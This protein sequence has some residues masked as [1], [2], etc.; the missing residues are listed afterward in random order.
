MK[1]D[2]LF[3]FQWAS[4]AKKAFLRRVGALCFALLLSFGGSLGLSS[5]ASATTRVININSVGDYFPIS[6]NPPRFN[7]PPAF[8]VKELGLELRGAC[9]YNISG[10]DTF[11]LNLDT[12]PLAYGNVIK[13]N[14][15]LLAN[16]GTLDEIY[17]HINYGSPIEYQLRRCSYNIIIEGGS[18]NITIKAPPHD[19]IMTLESS[20]V[21]G[22][23]PN[24]TINN[25]TLEGNG[26][27]DANVVGGI[28]HNKNYNLVLNNVTV[29]SGRSAW[30]CIFNTGSLI[31]NRSKIM[32]CRSSSIINGGAINSRGG[33]IATAG[34]EMVDSAIYADDPFSGGPAISNDA[35]STFI[36]NRSLV[37]ATSQSWGVRNGGQF[38]AI[39]SSI[40]SL[41][42]FVSVR[43]EPG[44]KVESLHST[45]SG[46]FQATGH[47]TKNFSATF[48]NSIVRHGCSF[49]DSG[50]GVFIQDNGGNLD[51]ASDSCRFTNVKSV[52]SPGAIQINPVPLNHGGPTESLKV[53]PGGLEQGRGVDAGCQD[54]R[55]SD[56]R[57]PTGALRVDQRGV[58]RSWTGCTSGSYEASEYALPLIRML[59]VHVV[60]TGSV[61]STGGLRD[62][63]KCTAADNNT[64]ACRGFFG[65]HGAPYLIASPPAGNVARFSG[66]CSATPH[67]QS[68]ATVMM[69]GS[70]RSCT[71]TFERPNRLTVVAGVGGIVNSAP[72]PGPIRCRFDSPPASCFADYVPGTQV[73]LMVEEDSSHVFD[74]WSGDGCVQNPIGI[75]ATVMMSQHR[76]C[77]AT[78]VPKPG[79]R[80][81]L[82]VNVVGEGSVRGLPGPIANCTSTG[83]VCSGDYLAD[84]DAVLFAT[85]AAGGA[86]IGWS[87]D[88][89]VFGRVKMDQARTCT[90]TFGAIGQTRYPVVVSVV[91]NGSVSDNAVPPQING[92]TSAGG[93]NCSGS[94]AGGATVILSAVP[95]AGNTFTGWDGAAWGGTGCTHTVV[96]PRSAAVTIAAGD[97]YSCK[98]TFEPI[99]G[100]VTRALTVSVVGD[101]SVSENAVPPQISACTS[102]GGANCSSNYADGATV[103]LT[104]TPVAGNDFVG[105]AGAGCTAVPGNPQTAWV[106]MDQARTCT[107]T[108]APTGAMTHALTVNV[109]GNGSV[110]DNAVPPQI[111]ACTSAGGA[112]CSGNHVDGATVTLK[113]TPV[114]GNNFTGWGGAGCTAVPGDPLSATV[115]M[116]QTRTCTAT[117]MPAGVVMRALTVNV[118]GNGSVSDNAV[119]PQISACTSAGGANCSGNYA[120]GATVTLTAVPVAG[121]NFTGWGG[122]GC[123]AVPGDPLSAT[124]TM[125]Q[126]RTC[127]ATFVPVA[128]AVTHT[129]TVSVT[130]NGSVNC[131]LGMIF[132][133]TAAG[134]ANCSSS[135]PM[136][137]VVLLMAAANA[138]HV[139]TGWGG[140]GC[141]AARNDPLS[142]T[143]TMDQARN[144][145]ARFEPAHPLTV[146]VI[147]DG[148]VSDN[149]MPRQI[150]DCDS[151]GGAAC[152]GD[153]AVGTLVT[154]MAVAD[155]GRAFTGWGGACTPVAGDPLSATVTMDQARTCE[156]TFVPLFTLTLN[157]SGNGGSVSDNAVPRQIN[158]CTSAGGAHCSGVY[159]AGTPLVLTA[160][161]SAG[162]VFD[163]WGDDC[164]AAGR[165]R[166]ATVAVN[167]ALSCRATFAAAPLAGSAETIPTLGYVALLLLIAALGMGA[168]FHP[169]IRKQMN[170]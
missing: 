62:I 127:T 83:G 162:F 154:L 100:A 8:T 67:N 151:A 129:L 16:F 96:S 148:K 90:A 45:F 14:K 88:C 50:S 42:N 27:P 19:N 31:L 72:F 91:G 114:A 74:G 120:D 118:A 105:W 46:T 160:T 69:N 68:H 5:P 121:N 167:A 104:A 111:S 3:F 153:Y 51:N 32:D 66:D 95:G 43:S 150:S 85:P 97:S 61:S 37:R 123:T 79:P 163:G 87:G 155:A 84:N 101:G 18:R 140:A 139:F 136:N 30:G 158:G 57:L 40:S 81:L 109:A 161:P 60:G 44:S 92:C 145:T 134:G 41:S 35:G 144:C 77:T 49:S 2:A 24:F 53:D 78:F 168:A 39:N 170:K 128:V 63:V 117:F 86:F 166:T 80:H 110:S 152:T 7:E 122:A 137:D 146:N 1:R 142:A 116:D 135:Y 54:P 58:Q 71:V 48:T 15:P 52:S 169:G 55:L 132:D 12:I 22:Q 4:L 131:L 99:A 130:G 36:M 25:V 10:H 56:P 147:G 141:T 47:L 13:L 59:T 70:D 20:G 76:T 113:A 107:A 143:V 157:V 119:P 124:V 17:S 38:T 125:D 73:S 82:T 75:G 23:I 112:N 9:S 138:G 106:S 64:Q 149:A 94:Y 108:F 6:Y 159:A 115:T 89:D 164:V 28:L 98:A 33:G 103:S 165:T 21:L 133:C 126:A 11:I 65:N 34:V 102:A 156:A 29:T 26:W 93:A